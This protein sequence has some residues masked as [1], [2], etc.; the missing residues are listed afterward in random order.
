MRT[1][2]SFEGRFP[3]EATAEGPPGRAIADI[4]REGIGKAGIRADEP[5]NRDDFAWDFECHVGSRRFEVLV[6]LCDD[7][8]GREWLAFSK[9]CAGLL[10]RLFGP[11]DTAEQ[12]ELNRALHAVLTSDARFRSVRWYT[13]HD[14]NHAPEMNWSESPA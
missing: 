14:W 5:W 6:G 2:V 10:G 11:R 9:P 13:E 12:A 1:H 8:G 3:K 4:L 7:V